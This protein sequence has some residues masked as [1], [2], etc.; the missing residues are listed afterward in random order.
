M[1]RYS[2]ENL[3]C[4]QCASKIESE[5]NRTPGVR[6]ASV[7]FATA[8]ICIDTDDIDNALAVVKK[9]EPRII[10]S[11]K[12]THSQKLSFLNFDLLIITVSILIAAGTYYISIQT[13]LLTHRTVQLLY[14]ISWITVGYSV[15]KTAVRNIFNGIIFDENFLM[16]L[17]TVCAFA[18]GAS[19]EAASVM[20]FYKTGEYL[21]KHT[22]RKSR[23]GITS[24]LSIKT[25]ESIVIRNSIE[26]R[27]NTNDIVTGESIKVLPGM[28]IPLDG[29]II[30]G[31]SDIDTSALTGESI[32]RSVRKGDEVY[33]GYINISGSLLIEVSRPASES[34]TSRIL[35]L[36]EDASQKKAKTEQFITRFARVYTPIIIIL[37]TLTALL[38]PL[39]TGASYSEWVYRAC[40][41]LVISCPCALVISIPLGYFGGI[42]GAAR[43]GILLKGSS[44]IDALAAVKTVV[45]DK[46]G[47]LTSGTFSVNEIIPFHGFSPEDIRLKAA[48]L[49]STSTHPISKSIASAAREKLAVHSFRERPGMGI[50]G[51]IDGQHII[52]GNRSLFELNE[53][54]V[55]VEEISSAHILVGIDGIFAGIILLSDTVKK[56]SKQ[57]VALLH[58]NNIKTIM[59]TGDSEIAARK[60]AE[61]LGIDEYHAQLLPHQ[62]LSEFERIMNGKNDGKFAFVGDGIND[63]PVLSRSDIGIAMG[64][65]GSDAAIESADAVIMTDS[66]SRIPDAIFHARKTRRII[67]Q[68]ITFAFAIKGLFIVLGSFGLAQMWEAVFADT[69]VA[70]LA[71]LNAMRVLR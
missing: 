69:G 68:N 64:A 35:S 17:S 36:V 56:D 7:N 45:F 30:S 10:I 13:D 33:A 3:D 1:K 21:Q 43:K 31:E 60:T 41:L 28:R 42:G 63:A 38:P 51:I 23:D 20:I 67:I 24:L 18:V 47:T 12:E 15:I 55:T 49:C 50:E 4:A 32:P 65:L 52:V 9:H 29:S 34:Y 19:A 16:T 57:T 2:I 46:T 59:L 5:L 40:V 39:I 22:I 11:E 61:E 53:I 71:V 27:V 54:A 70:L 62:K 14:G 66:P 37:A 25:E 44:V 26:V 8:S 58:D 6:Y 48:S